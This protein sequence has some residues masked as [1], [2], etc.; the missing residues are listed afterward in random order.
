MFGLFNYKGG[1]SVFYMI[2][3]KYGKEKVAEFASAFASSRTLEKALKSSLG[4][5]VEELN[6]E[7]HRWL[8]RQ[9]EGR[10]QNKKGGS[11]I[12]WNK[13]KP[14]EEAKISATARASLELSCRQL[15]WQLV[16]DEKMVCIG[17]HR[18]PHTEAGRSD[19]AR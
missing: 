8:K 15:A 3:Q 4:I 16:D 1:Q 13:L 11:A 6:E 10:V 17:E 18:L 9:G 12:P 14:G 7:W 2:E 5:G 19:Q